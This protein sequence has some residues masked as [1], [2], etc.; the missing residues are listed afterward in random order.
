MMPARIELDFARRRGYLSP[1]GALVLVLGCVVAYWTAEDYQESVLQ[2]QL[3]DFDLA[4]F[5]RRGA[6][7]KQAEDAESLARVTAATRALATP[8]TELLNDL[9]AAAQDS[10]MDIALLEVAPDRIKH[11]VRITAEARSLPLALDYVT[12]LQSASTLLYPVLQKHE[13]QT[14]DQERPVRFEIAAEW[15]LAQ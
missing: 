15:S 14:A 4:K 9:E 11:E 10:G 8:W 5:E 6:S 7:G 3:L 12:R 2:S 13:V 1:A